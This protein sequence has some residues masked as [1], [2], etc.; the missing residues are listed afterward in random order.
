M[1]LSWITVRTQLNNLFLTS[2][3]LWMWYYFEMCKIC[4][5]NAPDA[6]S[7]HSFFK[8]S[9]WVHAPRTP[10]PHLEGACLCILYSINN[11]IQVSS[12][13]HKILYETLISLHFL[14]ASLYHVGCHSSSA[15]PQPYDRELY[16][17]HTEALY[18]ALLIHLDDPMPCVQVS[19]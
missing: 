18:K 3:F 14:L 5:Q 19:A 4:L 13:K 10:P 12:P 16:S 15:F 8:I 9:W 2:K 17:A 6:I 11:F 1:W 7:E